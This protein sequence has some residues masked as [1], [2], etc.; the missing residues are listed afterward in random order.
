[1]RFVAVIDSYGWMNRYWTEGDISPDTNEPIPKESKLLGPLFRPLEAS[2]LTEIPQRIVDRPSA[3]D[4]LGAKSI[5]AVSG[6]PDLR[7]GE[8]PADVQK[9]R[10]KVAGK[11]K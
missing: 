3:D 5:P 8:I 6:V 10:Q 1:M 7:V 11:R 4:A 9:E 2:D